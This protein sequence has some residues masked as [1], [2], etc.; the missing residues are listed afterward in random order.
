MA[1][2][3][4]AGELT[5]VATGPSRRVH[6]ADGDRV[7]KARAVAQQVT[8]PDLG[9][10][11]SRLGKPGQEPLHGIVEAECTA[12]DELHH[13]RGSHDLRHRKPQEDGVRAGRC[14]RREVDHPRTGELTYLT[15]LHQHGRK[16]RNLPRGQLLK[17]PH[18]PHVAIHLRK[19]DE[20]RR[21]EAA[22]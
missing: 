19:S 17:R 10:P 15:T 22:H 20:T 4:L 2:E 18:Q 3:Q 14:P 5:R 16:T 7:R 9:P 6:P 1:L 11:R 13:R 8:N 12:F 21:T